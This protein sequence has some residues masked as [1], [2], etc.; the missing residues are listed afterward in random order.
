M[1]ARLFIVACFVALICIIVTKTAKALKKI[2]EEKD[3]K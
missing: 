1:F 3:K 2:T